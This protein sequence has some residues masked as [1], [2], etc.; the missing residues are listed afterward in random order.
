MHIVGVG[1]VIARV[2]HFLGF[3]SPEAPGTLRTLGMAL[4]FAVIA[5]LAAVLLA[6]LLLAY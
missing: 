5:T 4:T 1:F 3:R 6:Q 2:L